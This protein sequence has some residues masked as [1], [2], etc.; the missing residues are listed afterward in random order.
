MLFR[1]LAFYFRLLIRL[2][3]L[4]ALREQIGNAVNYSSIVIKFI[5]AN[6]RL[7]NLCVVVNPYL[8]DF[9]FR[10]LNSAAIIL[11]L[12]MHRLCNHCNKLV[13]GLICYR[14]LYLCIIHLNLNF[15]DHIERRCK[16]EE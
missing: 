11:K 8:L 15:R 10:G 13:L 16:L 1:Y 14:Y 7:N 4:K 5:C 2:N 3:L 6:I 12:V 9:V